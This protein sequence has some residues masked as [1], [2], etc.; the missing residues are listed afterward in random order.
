MLDL[1]NLVQ[2][3][4]RFCPV[5]YMLVQITS[6]LSLQNV[7]F[8]ISYFMCASLTFL[9]HVG[10][11]QCVSFEM[12]DTLSR[13]V[14]CIDYRYDQVRRDRALL[15]YITFSLSAHLWLLTVKEISEEPVQITA[16]IAI[17]HTPTDYFFLLTMFWTARVQTT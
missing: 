11:D 7:Y 12:V 9:S 17:I 5:L 10:Y 13:T 8:F 2:I 6:V 3:K 4:R 1:S 15:T 14:L 16:A